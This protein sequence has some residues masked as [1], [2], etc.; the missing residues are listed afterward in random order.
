[1]I[2]KQEMRDNVKGGNGRRSHEDGDWVEC[3]SM[4]LTTDPSRASPEFEPRWGSYTTT[5]L[6]ILYRSEITYPEGDYERLYECKDKL[7]SE[8]HNSMYGDVRRSLHK[9]MYEIE[10]S[11]SRAKALEIL[12][13][14]SRQLEQ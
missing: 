3:P 6:E 14:L 7:V 8:V 4:L 12:K 11:G 9:A 5:Q 13:H 2:T 10:M 1:M